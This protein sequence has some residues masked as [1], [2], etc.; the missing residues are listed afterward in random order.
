MGKWRRKD[1]ERYVSALEAT[2]SRPS[3]TVTQR[4]AQDASS[5]GDE[6]LNSA[7]EGMHDLTA[8]REAAAQI[9]AERAVVLRQYVEESKAAAAEHAAA[10]LGRR[11]LVDDLAPEPEGIAPDV[12]PSLPVQFIRTSAGGRLSDQHIADGDT[13]AKWDCRVSGSAIRTETSEKLSFFFLWQNPK[14]RNVRVDITSGFSVRGHADAHAEGSGF[15]ASLFFPDAR[16]DIELSARLTVWPLWLPHAP[17]PF[18]AID[19]ARC[20]V[21]GGTFSH[22]AAVA[23]AASPAFQ[24]NSYFV[25]REAYLLIE[26]GIVAEFRCLEGSGELDFA[27]ADSF[28]ADFPYCYVTEE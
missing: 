15:P 11:G 5:K 21:S 1:L 8:L 12:E 22:S 23:I 2:M 20:D 26:T 16:V 17:Q 25:P 7:I 3:S 18:Q 19:V 6:V 28:R 4:R 24:T 13:W 27:S 14:K 9:E 10:V